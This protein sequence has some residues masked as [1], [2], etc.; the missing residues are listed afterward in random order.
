MPKV[1]IER[2]KG[3]AMQAEQLEGFETERPM[4]R[5]KLDS[6]E[7]K[8][9]IQKARAR[10]ARGKVASGKTPADLRRIAGEQHR[11]DTRT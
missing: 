9:K 3:A 2:S 10:A 11:V 6:P 8:A 5:E 7:M 4:S 1:P